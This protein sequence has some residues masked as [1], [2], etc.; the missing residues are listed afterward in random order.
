MFLILEIERQQL[1][2]ILVS[3]YMWIEFLCHHPSSKLWGENPPAWMGFISSPTHIEFLPKLWP[4]AVHK[5]AR[6]KNPNSLYVNPRPELHLWTLLKPSFFLLSPWQLLQL[7]EEGFNPQGSLRAMPEAKTLCKLY[8]YLCTQ[9]REQGLWT[10]LLSSQDW[11]LYEQIR[12]YLGQGY[13]SVVF[14]FLERPQGLPDTWGWQG[15]GESRKQVS[16]LKSE[17]THQVPVPLQASHINSGGTNSRQ[18]VKQV[19]HAD[20]RWWYEKGA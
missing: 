5:H 17:N 18:G 11:H 2:S 13:H 4:C 15:G 10:H 19:N 14:L 8:Y 3:V 16:I 9:C 1:R 20:C 6:G 12:S 7:E